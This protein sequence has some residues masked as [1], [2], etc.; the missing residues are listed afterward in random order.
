MAVD[1]EDARGKVNVNQRDQNIV[2]VQEVIN[3]VEIGIGGPQGI[4]GPAGAPG[5]YT[6]SATE[7]VSPNVGDTW[8]NSSTAQMY[9]R[10]DGYW[11]ETSSSYVGPRGTTSVLSVQK[12]AHSYGAAGDVAGQLAF[13]SHYLYCCVADYVNDST[14]IWKRVALDATSW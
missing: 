6:V 9:I 11:V 12:P 10:Y 8:F 1:F 7:P 13:D 2:T 14:N 4:Q 5:S 3:K